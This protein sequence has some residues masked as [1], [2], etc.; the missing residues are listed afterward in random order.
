ME[1]LQFRKKSVPNNKQEEGNF[2]KN[3]RSFLSQRKKIESSAGS[4]YR[5]FDFI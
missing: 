1:L 2:E 4:R 5:S 3:Y